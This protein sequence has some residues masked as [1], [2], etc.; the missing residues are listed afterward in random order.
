L[1][2]SS[3]TQASLEITHQW[4][5]GQ[6]DWFARHVCVLA[7]HFQ[8]F[9][10]LPQEKQ[11]GSANVRSWLHNEA[12]QTRTCHWLISQK[13]GNVTLKQLQGTLNSTTMVDKAWM[14]VN[15]GADGHLYGWA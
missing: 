4:H 9:E 8:I 11:G 13:M 15:G 12:V 1:K 10:K 6:G 14:E 7:R 2:G 5:K 3:C